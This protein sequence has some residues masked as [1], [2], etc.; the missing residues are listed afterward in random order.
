MNRGPKQRPL[1]VDLSISAVSRI[2]SLTLGGDVRALAVCDSRSIFCS[3]GSAALNS[4][5]AFASLISDFNGAAFASARDIAGASH[6]RKAVKGA[7]KAH[8]KAK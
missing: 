7:R 2:T 3:V 4:E 8:N 5:I 6:N 1:R